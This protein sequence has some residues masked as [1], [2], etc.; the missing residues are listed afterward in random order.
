MLQTSACRRAQ[1]SPGRASCAVLSRL[2]NQVCVQDREGNRKLAD[3][4]ALDLIIGL[5]T[6]LALCSLGKITGLCLSSFNGAAGLG[7]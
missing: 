4:S 5:G 2:G 3:S 7:V 6:E 1:D